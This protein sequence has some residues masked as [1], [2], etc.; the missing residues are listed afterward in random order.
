MINKYKK[1]P[2]EVEAIQLLA[3]SGPNNIQE[4]LDFIDPKFKAYFSDEYQGIFID[5]LEGSMLAS[6]FDYIIKGV[7]G[8]FYPCKPDIFEQTYEKVLDKN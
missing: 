8:E 7:Q 2:L 5:T 1:I 4:C 3:G 6:E